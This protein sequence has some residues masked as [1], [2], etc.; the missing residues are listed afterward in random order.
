MASPSKAT[1]SAPAYLLAAYRR[2][3]KANQ[4]GLSQMITTALAHHAGVMGIELTQKD[5]EDRDEEN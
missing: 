4:T 5:D 2:L 3:A 1:I